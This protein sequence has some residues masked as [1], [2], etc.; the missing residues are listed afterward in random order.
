M[1]AY[2]GEDEL[3]YPDSLEVSTSALFDRVPASALV[4]VFEKRERA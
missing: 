2:T 4:A 1:Q 3:F